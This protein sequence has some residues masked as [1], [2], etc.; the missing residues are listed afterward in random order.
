M[1]SI[2]NNGELSRV[3]A[4]S[5]AVFSCFSLLY[6]HVA[7]IKDQLGLTV[8]EHKEANS[9]FRNYLILVCVDSF[10]ILFAWFKIGLTFGFP[11]II[12]FLTGPLCYW[13]GVWSAKRTADGQLK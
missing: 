11:G 3:E 1:K 12:Y 4:F 10:S 2:I 5:D 9:L 6:L 7:R 13:N 8:E